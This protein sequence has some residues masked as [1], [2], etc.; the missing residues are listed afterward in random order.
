MR[1]PLDHFLAVISL[2]SMLNKV[3]L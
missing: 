3:L 2:H 1:L